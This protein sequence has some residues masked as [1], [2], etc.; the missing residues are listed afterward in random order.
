MVQFEKLSCWKWNLRTFDFV[1]PYEA[2]SPDLENFSTENFSTKKNFFSKFPNG[3]IRKVIGSK[4][5]FETFSLFSPLRGHPC[6]RLRK[7]FQV[8]QVKYVKEDEQVG[9][10]WPVMR[11]VLR[12]RPSR[13]RRYS[14]QRQLRLDLELLVGWLVVVYPFPGKR[15]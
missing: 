13:L 3:S 2:M 9:Q 1:F 12:L 4:S 15:L 6:S 5:K 14:S 7:F 10:S 8:K 11:S